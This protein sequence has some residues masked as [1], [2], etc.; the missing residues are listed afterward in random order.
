[1]G[2]EKLKDRRGRSNKRVGSTWWLERKKW[3][4]GE[5][6]KKEEVRGHHLESIENGWPARRGSNHIH[7]QLCLLKLLPL[8]LRLALLISLQPTRPGQS[9]GALNGGSLLK[10]MT[11][12]SIVFERGENKSYASARLPWQTF[13]LCFQHVQVS[14]LFWSRE[15]WT[16]GGIISAEMLGEQ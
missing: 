11:V 7:Q 2:R 16:K 6:R 15:R 5:E 4:G 3:E 12:I 10:M 14:R 9:A 1:M 8:R 13:A